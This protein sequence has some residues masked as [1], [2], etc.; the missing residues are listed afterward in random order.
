MDLRHLRY[1]I[2]VAEEMNFSK[3]A[4]QLRMAQPPLSQQIR[5]LENEIGLQLFDRSQRQIA[6]TQAGKDFLEDARQVLAS[7]EHLQENARLRSEGKLGRLSV[8][9]IS[10]MAT[11]DFAAMLRTFQKENPLIELSLG[12]RPSHS[13]LEA[14]ISGTLDVGFLRPP[15]GS[16]EGLESFR[17]KKESM[18]V[19]VPTSHPLSQKKR[20]S[21][22]D[23]KNE[24]LVLVEPELAP[25]HYDEFFARC[26]SA[27]VEPRIQQYTVNVATQLWLSSA[28]LGIAPMVIAPDLA[29]RD[30]VRFLELPTD[31]PVYETAMVY[32]KGDRSP[33][34][35][36]FVQFVK[37]SVLQLK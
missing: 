31:A 17:L 26:R 24:P 9:V 18:R 25:H 6:L 37:K 3:A 22:S 5:D 20:L 32:R 11:P 34:L 35:L 19:A 30:G 2:A 4:R 14:L 29:S 13:Q 15:S 23:L 8:S 27:G 1:F 28:G 21:W 16:P 12:D 7:V 10:S 36:R 33:G